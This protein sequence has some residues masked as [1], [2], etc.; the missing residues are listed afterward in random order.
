MER[1]DGLARALDTFEEDAVIPVINELSQYLYNGESSY[2]AVNFCICNKCN[3]N[4]NYAGKCPKTSYKI[5]KPPVMVKALRK[6][7]KRFWGLC[8]HLIFVVQHPRLLKTAL[9][10]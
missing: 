4:S 8:S 3:N 1:L 9:E 10:I 7:W 6:S 5:K 2:N